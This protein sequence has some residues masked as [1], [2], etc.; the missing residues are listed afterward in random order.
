MG[1]N[2][3][4]Y[5]NR[6]LLFCVYTFGTHPLLAPTLPVGGT[7]SRALFCFL[8]WPVM[9]D[10]PHRLTRLPPPASQLAFSYIYFP[11]L[12]SL[13]SFW[14]W[15]FEVRACDARLTCISLFSWFVSL[16]HPDTFV[17]IFDSS[18]EQMFFFF[19]MPRWVFAVWSI[20]FV[21][22]CVILKHW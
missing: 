7:Q 15:G 11:L 22:V 9:V 8:I 20:S 13:F 6:G 10:I 21:S 19:F 16:R 2:V 1:C 12:L 4:L 5:L 3:F 18:G 14:L 17:F